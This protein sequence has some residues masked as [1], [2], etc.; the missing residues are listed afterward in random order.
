M[1]C[2]IR[3]STWWP[4]QDTSVERASHNIGHEHDGEN[5]N[6]DDRWDQRVTACAVKQRRAKKRRGESQSSAEE[7]RRQAAPQGTVSPFL[8]TG[9]IEDGPSGPAGWHGGSEARQRV[10]NCKEQGGLGGS[11]LESLWYQVASYL[12][13]HLSD[14]L[15]IHP[16]AAADPDPL[17]AGWAGYK[18][19]LRCPI[20][21]MPPVPFSLH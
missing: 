1:E 10:R 13:A 8:L 4:T 12:I 14:P 9:W 18:D 15:D 2:R 19:R 11:A 17:L 16:S 3:P 20:C 7:G 5:E 6:E 21:Q